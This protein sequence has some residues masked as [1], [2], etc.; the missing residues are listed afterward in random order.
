M[1]YLERCADKASDA[2]RVWSAR[3]ECMRVYREMRL[4]DRAQRRLRAWQQGQPP[5]E[6]VEELQ[7][8]WEE[9]PV[10]PLPS[11]VPSPQPP[12]T[13][14][15]AHRLAILNQAEMVRGSGASARG[16][17]GQ[18]RALL[19]EHLARWPESPTATEVSQ[20]AAQLAVVE[21]R[22]A[23][24]VTLVDVFDVPLDLSDEQ[25][26]ALARYRIETKEDRRA[27]VRELAALVENNPRDGDLRETYARRLAESR[28]VVDRRE[29]LQVWR[30]VERLS[31]P[32]GERWWRARQA[33][34]DLL[35]E[36]GDPAAERLDALTRLL[37]AAEGE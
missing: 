37:H 2:P 14:A 18:Y 7:R 17:L 5:A 29:A 3:V 10:A 4:T 9:E 19:A 11:P 25:R 13:P 6:A 20:W 31:R 28:S 1:H 26:A 16:A 33:R 23:D 8:A 35:R 36:L 12:I 30:T 15:A 22:W 21:G 32:Q 34:I 24:V 27:A